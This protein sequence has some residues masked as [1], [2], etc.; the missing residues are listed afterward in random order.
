MDKVLILGAIGVAALLVPVNTGV[1]VLLLCGAGI[2][3]LLRIMTQQPAAC[4]DDIGEIP[5]GTAHEEHEIVVHEIDHHE[6][7]IYSRRAGDRR[8]HRY[9]FKGEANGQVGTQARSRS[10]REDPRRLEA[11]SRP[12]VEIDQDYRQGEGRALIS[13]G[14]SRRSDDDEG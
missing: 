3:A 12:Q 4:P 13:R 14:S 7:I 6:R 1:A 9:V 5:T 2:Y 8:V 11:R 10:D